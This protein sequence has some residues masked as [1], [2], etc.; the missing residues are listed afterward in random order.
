M[1][2]INKTAALFWLVVAD[3]LLL[4]TSCKT[5]YVPVEAV[6]R[7]S[8]Y[9]NKVQRDSIFSRDSIYVRER[10]DTVLVE[11]YKY[12]FVDKWLRDTAYISRTDSVPYPVEVE[13]KLNWW[14]RQK[15]KLGGGSMFLN[16]ALISIII[17]MWI[18]KKGGR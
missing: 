7:D 2:T 5:K 18:K 16:F 10:G 3:I 1:K 17:T 4:L 12:L 14:Q 13:K 8:I 11:R 6:K 9:I 15:M